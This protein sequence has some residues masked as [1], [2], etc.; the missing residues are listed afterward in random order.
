MWPLTDHGAR[1]VRRAE[2][3]SDLPTPAGV[4]PPSPPG[5]FVVRALFI[6]VLVAFVTQMVVTDGRRQPYPALLPP[7]FGDG[8]A[9]ADGTT[10]RPQATVV[11]TFADGTTVRYSHL[12]VMGVP[13]A[14]PLRAMQSGYGPTSPR[15]EQPEAMAWLWDRVAALRHEEPVA[16]VVEWRDVV[17]DLRGEEPTRAVLTD[18][19]VTSHVTEPATAAGGGRG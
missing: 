4:R 9:L 19:F 10:V 15:R 1:G 8:S 12:E 13:V 17:Y 3:G 18:R 14:S 11:A 5:L 7:A 2:W 16:V 6:A